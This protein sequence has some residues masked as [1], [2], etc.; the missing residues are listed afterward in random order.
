MGSQ[1]TDKP[2]VFVTKKL[3][4]LHNTDT[5]LKTTVFSNVDEKQ[6]IDFYSFILKFTQYYT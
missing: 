1:K 5:V 3:L 4:K 6:I 2:M